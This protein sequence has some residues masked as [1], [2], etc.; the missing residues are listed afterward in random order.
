M[1]CCGGQLQ[2]SIIIKS[3]ICHA[4]NTIFN[5]RKSTKSKVRVYINSFLLSFNFKSVLQIMQE[6]QDSN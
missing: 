3:L 5:V 4:G 2:I 6:V 1:L